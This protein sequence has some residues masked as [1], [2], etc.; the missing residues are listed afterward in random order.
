MIKSEDDLLLD[1]VVRDLYRSNL[2]DAMKKLEE[3]Y[4]YK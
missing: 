1:T 2:F 4:I 3:G